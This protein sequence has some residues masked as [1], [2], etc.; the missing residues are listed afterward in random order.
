MAIPRTRSYLTSLLHQGRAAMRQACLRPFVGKQPIS[1]QM[2]EVAFNQDLSLACYLNMQRCAAPAH[3]IFYMITGN[4]MNQ[5]P[6]D[7]TR[8]YQVITMLTALTKEVPEMRAILPNG[9]REQELLLLCS[10]LFDV[11][12]R[13]GSWDIFTSREETMAVFIEVIIKDRVVSEES[14]R[15][16]LEL[17]GR[18][19]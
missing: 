16:H 2:I 18:D 1:K 6:R 13:P 7:W 15:T 8:V 17:S 10:K 11:L 12:N 19:A 14:A 9:E 3:Y 4:R 5:S